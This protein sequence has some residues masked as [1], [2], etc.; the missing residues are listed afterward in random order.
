MA[1]DLAIIDGRYF[2]QL[3]FNYDNTDNTGDITQKYSFKRVKTVNSRELLSNKFHVNTDFTYKSEAS[4]SLKFEGLGEGSANVEYTI[5][6]DTAYE[7]QKTSETSTTIEE[8]SSETREYTVGPGGK[9]SLYQLH[10]TTDGVNVEADIFATT[11][12]PDAIVKLKFRAMSRILGLQDILY[13][14]SHTF[15]ERSNKNEWERISSSIV[16]NSSQPAETQFRLFVE[17]LSGIVPG[18]SNTRE[19]AG[20]RNTCEEILSWWDNTDKQLLFKKLISRFSVTVPESE[21]QREWG[22]IRQLSDEILAGLKEVS[23]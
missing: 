14:F 19:W 16:R 9:L 8:E 3:V 1:E 5:H 18:S 21:N 4:A 15:P 11:P 20:I 10:Y 12:Q 6:L 2:W 7:L 13:L 22:K 23:A 17:T